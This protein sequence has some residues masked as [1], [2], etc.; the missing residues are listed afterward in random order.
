MY[1]WRGLRVAIGVVSAA[2]ALAVFTVTINASTASA[3]VIVKLGGPGAGSVESNPR[4]SSGGIDCSNV[5][6]SPDGPKCSESFPA[7][8]PSFEPNPIELTA[9]AGPGFMFEGW[10]GDDPL[11]FFVEPQSCNASSENACLVFDPE[12][13]AELFGVSPDT[14]ITATFGCVPPVAAPLAVTGGA[15]ETSLI[16]TVE[17]TVN[18][19]G[20]GLE[21]SYFE[22]GP[23]TEYG[24]TTLT[25]P[26]ISG[27]GHGS[28]PILVTAE[29]EPLEP[30]TTYHYRLV[31]VGPGGTSIGEDRT[32]TT[33]PARPGDCSNEARRV[34]QG[35]VA[36]HLP[37]C[38]ALEMVSPPQKSGAPAKV[39]NVSADGS[40]VSFVSEAALGENPGGVFNEVPYVASRDSSGWTSESTVPDTGLAQQWDILSA[41][42]PSFTPDFSRWFGIGATSAQLQQGMGQAYEAGLSGF[43]QPP[44]CT[45]CATFPWSRNA[46]RNCSPQQF[47]GG[48]GR[49]LP[50]LFRTRIERNL[51]ARRSGTRSG[52]G[53]CLPGAPRPWWTAG[54]TTAARPH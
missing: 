4:G 12:E 7:F 10:T 13:I 9:A 37:E 45:P 53:Q 6:G 50:P 43:F 49:P 3:R 22:Y 26:N 36:L 8:T 52:D 27:I 23:T 15:N 44:L 30:E 35:V 25:G 5:N 40:R 19:E 24:S 38:M 34:E 51:P 2:L 32:L 41:W 14:H 21:E 46:P 48:V 17:G 29:T 42:N 54:P 18:P 39:P 1:W 33:T 11:A 28:D 31:V 16:G 20:C 47:P